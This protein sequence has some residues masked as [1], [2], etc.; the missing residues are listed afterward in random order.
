[1]P[2]FTYTLVETLV[3]AGF[4]RFRDL[5]LTKT[6]HFPKLRLYIL[7]ESLVVSRG[8]DF[9]ISQGLDL[10]LYLF[11]VPLLNGLSHINYNKTTS[12]DHVTRR[13]G[14]HGH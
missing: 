13:G 6:R 5:T 3:K 4:K 8:L 1:M 11:R 9:T 14:T 10:Q 7:L 2:R 12:T